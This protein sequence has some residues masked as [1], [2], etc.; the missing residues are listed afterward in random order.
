MIPV[1]VRNRYE[2]VSDSPEFVKVMLRILWTLFSKHG[3]Y[4]YFYICPS[5]LT[6]AAIIVVIDQHVHY[7][8]TIDYQIIIV[9]Q[10]VL[11]YTE[12]LSVYGDDMMI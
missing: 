2:T 1:S 10:I 11:I 8:L 12:L 4:A 7:L 5:C 9:Q 6:M 3:A